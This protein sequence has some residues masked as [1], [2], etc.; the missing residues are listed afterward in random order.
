MS[1]APAN[2]DLRSAIGTAT[3]LSGNSDV[4][5]AREA[6]RQRKLRRL[7]WFLLSTAL[8]LLVRAYMGNPYRFSIPTIPLDHPLLP[9]FLLVLVIGIGGVV[10]M[11][12]AGRSPHTLFRSED[13][14]VR[15]TDVVGAETVK[16]EVVRSLNLFL[17]NKTFA[18]EMGGTMRRGL[19]FSGAPGTGKTYIAK[20]MAG[21][22][23]VPFVFVSATA[24]QSMFYGATARK[25]RSYFKALRK[26][27]RKEGG[28]I[29]FIEE[30][31]AIGLSRAGMTS[32]HGEGMSGV[33]NE[34]L[35]QM[36]SFD[37][38]AA[39]VR[40]QTWMI[41]RINSFL[42]ERRRVQRPARLAPN[43]IL[44]AATNRASDLDPALLRAGRFD[45]TITFDLPVRRERNQ[46]AGFYLNKKSHDISVTPEE[47]AQITS[48]CSPVEIEQLLDEGLVA[49]L[50]RGS[51]AMSMEDIKAAQLVLQVGLARDGEYTTGERWRVAVHESGHGI[52][53]LLLGHDVGLVSILKRAS[54]LGVT[55]HTTAEE[56]HL[57]TRADMEAH[58]QIALAGMVAEELECGEMSSGASSD[59]ASATSTVCQ[60]IGSLGMG[61]SLLCLDASQSRISGNIVDKVLA[62]EP[63]RAAA[64]K[65]LLECKEKVRMLLS[66]RRGPL[67]RSAQ[68]L[69]D[70]DE[71]SGTELTQILAGANASAD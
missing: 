3:I 54:A 67:R 53:S 52:V 23:G 22:A 10:P 57:H 58:I 20:A 43:I 25:I 41:E 64:D 19:L 49:A 65:L 36:Q 39:G 50:R 68:A 6:Y 59:L 5:T 33:V 12:M 34:L 7:S 18:T 56:I 26:V 24:F 63:S 21:S 40:F 45:R 42:P 11:L 47:I 8:F 35:V 38:P 44:I 66:A 46:I 31:D 14:A 30:F 51:R 27:A 16:D 13:I 17:A 28:V 70:R 60:M 32:G 9:P 2:V 1:S 15:L 37:E 4:A 61:D 48:G 71:I 55:T 62:D 29:G 69:L